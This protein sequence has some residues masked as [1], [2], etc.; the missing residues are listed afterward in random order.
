MKLLGSYT[1]GNY[2][3]MIFEDGTKIR[4]NDEDAFHPKFPESIDL[5]ISNSCDMNCPM[6]HENSWEGGPLANLK[7]PIFDEIKAGT[8]LALGGGNVFEHPDL[9]E[10]L[11]R[12]HRKGVICNIT[13]HVRHFIKYYND[14]QYYVDHQWIHGIGV[15][16]NEPVSKGVVEMINHFPN[17][18]VHVIAGIVDEEILAPLRNNNIKLLILGYKNYGRG[19]NYITSNP[20][21]EKIT[22]LNDQLAA[23]RQQFKILSF[24]NLALNQLFVHRLVPDKEWKVS[25]MGDDGRFTMYIDLVRE[26][27]AKSSISPRYL[28]LGKNIEEMFDIVK[29]EI[30]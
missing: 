23:M 5:K 30:V 14:I 16:I 12:M 28:I 21:I 3:V 10:F 22:W 19:K 1:N 11:M 27:F 29:K 20:V 7:H 2:E 24:D 9:D 6:C 17:A 13:V 15:S 26:Q 4:I 25:Y 8:E 18:V